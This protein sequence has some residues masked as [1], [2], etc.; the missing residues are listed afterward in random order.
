MRV[1]LCNIVLRQKQ[2]KKREDKD[3]C[4][5]CS[6]FHLKNGFQP[7]KHWNLIHQFFSIMIPGKNSYVW[8]IWDPMRDLLS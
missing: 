7:K 2:Q 3:D 6:L 5:Q 4:F 1:I 8:K